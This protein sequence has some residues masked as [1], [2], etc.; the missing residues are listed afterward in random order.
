M[1]RRLGWALLVIAL[2]VLLGYLWN[3]RA[4]PA[5]PVPPPVTLTKPTPP[6]ATPAVTTSKAGPTASAVA[7]PAP[8][9]PVAIQDNK[10]VDFSSGK[11]VVKNSAEDKAAIDAAVKEMD[12]ATKDITFGPTPSPPPKK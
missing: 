10:T 4:T 11:P 7:Q 9:P 12:A 3:R 6:A 1:Q 8:N 2:G 5:A